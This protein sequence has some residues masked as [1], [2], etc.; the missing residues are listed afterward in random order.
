[1]ENSSPK[2][3][4]EKIPFWRDIRVLRVLF[5]VIFLIG[6][7]LLAGILYTNM[8]RGL[9]GLG[10]TLNLDFLNDE[11]GFGISEGI[12]YEPSDTYLKSVLGGRGKHD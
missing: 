7:L 11:A 2:S 12:A 3:V 8:L 5:Q 10:L 1:M 9:R 4:S 6:V